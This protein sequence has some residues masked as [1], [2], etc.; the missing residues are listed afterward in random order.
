MTY[1]YLCILRSKSGSHEQPSTTE[2]E[3]KLK[4]YQSWQEQFADRFFDMGAALTEKG[5]IVSKD[6]VKDDPFMETKE[7]IGGFM[8]LQANSLDEPKEV[9]THSRMIEDPN[10][11][12]ELR[13]IT[14]Q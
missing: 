2:M 10:V 7:I 3:A 5:A 13:A 6:S 1:K 8:M 14:T 12:I 11:S 4:R 9:I